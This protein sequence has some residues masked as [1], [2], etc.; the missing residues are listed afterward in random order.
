[1]GPL[2]DPAVFGVD[3][4]LAPPPALPGRRDAVK[5]DDVEGRGSPAAVPSGEPT[6]LVWLLLLL[7]LLPWWLSLAP[8]GLE[9]GEDEGPD[10]AAL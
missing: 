8:P 9:M 3:A 7:L 10:P 6:A 2:E 4:P 5:D 1:M